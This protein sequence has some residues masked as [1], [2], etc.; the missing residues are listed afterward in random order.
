LAQ[1]DTP[2]G[3]SSQPGIS[4]PDRAHAYAERAD[5]ARF[6]EEISQRDG[7]D[8]AHLR[9][10]FAQVRFDP[11]ILRLAAPAAPG[12][13]VSW[14]RYRAR[15]LDALHLREGTQFWQ[16]HAEPIARAAL[17]CGVD[18]SVIVALIGVETFYG[19]ITGKF[20]I[21]DALTVLGFDDPRRAAFFRDE[22]EQF[23]LLTRDQDIDPLGVRGSFAGAIGWPQFMPSSIRRWAVD[24]DGDG[25]IDLS[26]SPVDA[27]GS[28]AN[29]LCAHGWKRDE[30]PRYEPIIGEKADLKALIEA[31]IEPRFTPA[32]LAERG[33][34]LAAAVPA[35]A[36]LALVELPNDEQPPTRVV[37]AQNFYVITRY[38]RSSFYAMAVLDLAQALKAAR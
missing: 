1:A 20:R 36:H 12:F 25:R 7:F 9:T 32:E 16:S 31:G 5:V 6:I 4:K 18:E 13:R 3:A 19:R 15:F 26:G 10:L 17:T 30:P 21:I 8:P 22:L 29:F 37:A 34:L 11:V 38:N 27:I 35:D 2:Q 23:L 28:V 33:V 14:Q 24:F